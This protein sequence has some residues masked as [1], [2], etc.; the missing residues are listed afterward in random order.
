MQRMTEPD[1][2]KTCYDPWELCR[3]D[4]DCTRGCHEEGGCTKGCRVLKMYRKLA[5]YKDAEEQG[6]LIRLPLRAGED[7]FCLS[8][9]HTPCSA[10]GEE[11]GSF[12]CQGCEAARCDSVAE[13][14]IRKEEN[15]VLPWIIENLGNFG[16]TVFAAYEDAE[17]KLRELQEG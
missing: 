13:P 8:S 11:R 14:C 4:R 9:R 2:N 15:A 1:W 12:A 7:A 6:L 16:K 10:Y 17:R 5:E 3:M